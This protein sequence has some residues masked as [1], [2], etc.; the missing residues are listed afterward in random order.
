MTRLVLDSFAW[1]EEITGTPL[2][3]IVRQLIED[4]HNE[5]FTSTVTVP[6]V[7][8][9]AQ[10]RGVNGRKTAE[11]IEVGSI[12]VPMDFTL[13]V[14]TGLIHAERKKRSPDFS[15]GDAAVTALARLMRARI[16]TGD[17]HFKDEPDVFFLR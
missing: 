5:T 13:A 4:Q 2:G 9:H 14:S 11:A 12:V 1:I 6:E 15:Y 3:S 17:A 16:V 7:V 10:R 8:S